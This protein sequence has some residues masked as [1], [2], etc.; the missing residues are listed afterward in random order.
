MTAKPNLLDVV[1]LREPRGSQ[2]AG[3]IGAVVELLATEALVEITDDHGK[4]LELLNV[5]TSSY[6]S[7]SPSRPLAVPPDSPPRAETSQR[8]SRQGTYASSM[9]PSSEGSCAV[10]DPPDED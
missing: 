8:N 1:E 5:P 6:V 2:P 7:E 4:T 10:A 3:A 9:L